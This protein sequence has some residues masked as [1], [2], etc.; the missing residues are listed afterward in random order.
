MFRIVSYRSVNSST[1]KIGI[2]INSFAIRNYS[3]YD[4]DRLKRIGR[5]SPPK[6]NKEFESFLDNEGDSE[7]ANNINWDSGTDVEFENRLKE[8]RN[9]EK[10]FFK[11]H[12]KMVGEG[13]NRRRVLNEDAPRENISDYRITAEEMDENLD[14][15][16]TF[17]DNP[18]Y[19]SYIKS[20][21]ENAQ[22][23][24]EK[25]MHE[26]R[27]N[28]FSK[29]GEQRQAE[30]KLFNN[31]D[32]YRSKVLTQTGREKN[33][34]EYL[35]GNY[36]E[37]GFTQDY[38][39]K[40]F[41]VSDDSEFDLESDQTDAEQKDI[42]EI[43]YTDKSRYKN[44]AKYKSGY[45]TTTKHLYQNVVDSGDSD[46]VSRKI[47][48][49]LDD[50]F[51]LDAENEAY[52]QEDFEDGDEFMGE[53]DAAEEN[54]KEEDDLP[55]E[56]FREHREENVETP[57]DGMEKSTTD[58]ESAGSNAIG[59]DDNFDGSSGDPE[60]P[61]D[62]ENPVIRPDLNEE[63]WS[64]TEDFPEDPHENIDFDELE[65]VPLPENSLENR[66]DIL[67]QIL[68][69]TGHHCKVTTGGRIFS[70]SALVL[71][72]NGDGVAGLGYGKG[73]DFPAALTAAVKDAKKKLFTIYMCDNSVSYQAK[74][75]YCRS[76]VYIWP[77]AKNMG[78][79]G[80][81]SQQ[82]I[83]DLLGL[84]DIRIKTHGRRNNHNVY[85]FYFFLIVLRSFFL[86]FFFFYS[87]KALIRCLQ[88][89]ETPEMHARRRG[90]KV[91]DVN[92]YWRVHNRSK[93]Y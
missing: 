67:H 53:T 3:D 58:D 69:K 23:D 13:I 54:N 62:T 31:R 38:L 46:N 86:F 68:L 22:K 47:N 41:E 78:I 81:Y 70:S 19:K 6:R 51:Q 43:L 1:S 2:P 35:K 88:T 33:T 80:S 77:L 90:K 87:Y 83:C 59:T 91:W 17:K 29:T 49:N 50:E 27:A 21:E 92:K 37:P 44:L 34:K 7:F 76:R 82:K 64:S 74:Q 71:I 48:Q 18:R 52:D 39:P 16:G 36:Y 75:K 10:K 24:E 60:L 12:S 9:E 55:N 61:S 73:E 85:V 32:F 25:E 93:A 84:T 5:W 4:T 45:F 26:L 72:G 42:A 11:K 28:L 8:V 63:F 40:V 57:S 20:F 30:R 79:R 15:Y 65:N 89:S 14:D 66:D 56:K